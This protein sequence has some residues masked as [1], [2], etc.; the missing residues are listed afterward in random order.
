M[1]IFGPE[2]RSKFEK[3]VSDNSTVT[4]LFVWMR[5]PLD[6]YSWRVCNSKI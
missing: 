1:L 5:A 6:P 2:K 4:C 3:Q